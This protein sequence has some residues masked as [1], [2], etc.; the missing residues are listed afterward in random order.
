MDLLVLHE[1]ILDDLAFKVGDLNS[2]D[3]QNIQTA[4]FIKDGRAN[5]VEAFW[6]VKTQVREIKL[7]DRS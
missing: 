2:S 3:F 4:A 1:D 5:V 7:S 6:V